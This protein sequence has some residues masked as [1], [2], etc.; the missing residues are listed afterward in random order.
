MRPYNKLNKEVIDFREY[1]GELITP[2]NTKYLYCQD[3]RNIDNNKYRMYTQYQTPIGH[4]RKNKY[5]TKYTQNKRK[6]GD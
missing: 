5:L 6:V 2:H 1:K 3:R 4:R